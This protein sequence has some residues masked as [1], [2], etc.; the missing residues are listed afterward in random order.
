M[1]ET[2]VSYTFT[3]GYTMEKT[4]SKQVPI[5]GLD[6]K[7]QITVVLAITLSGLLLPP[8]VLYQGKTE[9]CHPPKGVTFPTGWDVWHS[10]THWAN[11][12]TMLR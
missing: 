9:A 12:D 5:I 2:G 11:E 6:D 4:G 7:R 8:Q 1:D 10:E 3:G